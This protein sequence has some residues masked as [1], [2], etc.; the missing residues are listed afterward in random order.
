MNFQNDWDDDY[1]DE[2]MNLENDSPIM[3]PGLPHAGSMQ[4]S[5]WMQGAME[6]SD[7]KYDLVDTLTN[8][9]AVIACTTYR[10]AK[11]TDASSP[12]YVSDTTLKYVKIIVILQYQFYLTNFQ[13]RKL[14]DEAGEYAELGKMDEACEDLIQASGEECT[15]LAQSL[16]KLSPDIG[17]LHFAT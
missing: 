6:G 10:T 8:C 11:K 15:L 9:R 3:M 17:K 4:L 5:A 12:N 7:L 13:Y 2:D 14:L 1:E 16:G